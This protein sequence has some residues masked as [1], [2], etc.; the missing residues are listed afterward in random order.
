LGIRFGADESAVYDE[1]ND[2][3][4]CRARDWKLSLLE[5]R[6]HLLNRTKS[7]QYMLTNFL[8]RVPQNLIPPSF[9]RESGVV[10]SPSKLEEFTELL[11]KERTVEWISQGAIIQVKYG[12]MGDFMAEQTPNH[13]RGEFRCR[14]TAR[15]GPV[16]EFIR[17]D[18]IVQVTEHERVPS[19]ALDSLETA[20]RSLEYELWLPDGYSGIFLL[21]DISPDGFVMMVGLTAKRDFA[22]SR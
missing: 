17:V 12:Q 5:A 7:F 9:D 21:D 11:R 4:N 8:V 20:Q 1:K 22:F 14:Q 6:R 2:V 16:G 18:G 15:A 10:L 19:P 13:P 3:L